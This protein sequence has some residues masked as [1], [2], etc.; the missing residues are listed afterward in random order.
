[1][2]VKMSVMKQQTLPIPN[3]GDWITTMGAAFLLGVSRRTI[4]RMAEKGV[5]TAYRPYGAPDEV[6]PVLFWRAQ[7]NDVLTARLTV[8]GGQR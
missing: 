1:M 8:A 4:E 6:T 7:V 5:L 2:P 3:P